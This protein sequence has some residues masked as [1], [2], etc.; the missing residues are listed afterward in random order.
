MKI[1]SKKLLEQRLVSAEVALAHAR[2]QAATAKIVML[3]EEAEVDRL[4]EQLDRLK[5][6]PTNQSDVD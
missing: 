3:N 4:Q 6:Q 1:H 5:E 2:Q